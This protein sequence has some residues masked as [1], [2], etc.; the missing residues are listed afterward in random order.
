MDSLIKLLKA[1]C[2][3]KEF[4]VK[5]V[6][7]TLRTLTQSEKEEIVKRVY[8]LNVIAENELMKKPILGYAL[9]KINNSPILAYP[10]LQNKLAEN[11]DKQLPTNLVVESF[12]DKVS[13]N[14]TYYLYELY[15]QL[16]LEEM[17]EI[18]ELKKDSADLL[19]EQSTNSLKK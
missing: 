15:L 16:D 6:K 7:I 11:K 14:F 19:A 1:E 10:E 8:A 4:D 5:G 9:V 12:L 17:R 3:Y 13:S 18:Q 2:T